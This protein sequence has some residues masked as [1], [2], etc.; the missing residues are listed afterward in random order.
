MAMPEGPEVKT[1]ARTLAQS[2]VG[3]TLDT[4]WHSSFSLRIK[5][6]Y[7]QFE[8]LCGHSVDDVY[9]YGK[10]IFIGVNKKPALIAQLGMTG[11]LVVVKKTTPVL[12]HTHLRW[13]LLGQEDELRYVDQRRFGLIN[14]CDEA[15]ERLVLKKLARIHFL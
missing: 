1:V 8:R 3:R 14:V 4:F 12:P 2:L 13:S 5:V 9:S 11:Q 7:Q 15:Q 6:D 10:V